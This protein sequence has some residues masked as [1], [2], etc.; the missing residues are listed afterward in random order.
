[1]RIPGGPGE[2]IEE[3]ALAAAQDVQDLVEQV[4]GEDGAVR[5]G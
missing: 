5:S 2:V 3:G 1:M 4:N